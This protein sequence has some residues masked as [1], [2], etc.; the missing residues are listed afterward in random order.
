MPTVTRAELTRVRRCVIKIGSALVTNAGQ[1]L[2]STAIADWAAQVAQLRG[3]SI[4][5]VI[6]TSGAV[7]AGMQRLGRRERPHALHELQA[8]AAVG[9]MGL[10]Q[11]Y[12]TAFQ[13]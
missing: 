3:K 9:Q 10:V 13:R 2:D 8:M 4:E 5:C 11:V 7:A 6:V 1:G 12:E